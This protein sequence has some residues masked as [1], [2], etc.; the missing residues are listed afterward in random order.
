MAA[1]RAT[2]TKKGWGILVELHEQNLTPTQEA[3]IQAATKRLLPQLVEVVAKAHGVKTPKV[4]RA[5]IKRNLP[6]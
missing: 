3:N 5:G 2:G 4:N 6:I 1:T